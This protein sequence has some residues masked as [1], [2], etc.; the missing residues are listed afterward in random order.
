M[1]KDNHITR[2][3]SAT[4]VKSNALD[5]D[6]ISHPVLL[7]QLATVSMDYW[8]E[9]S[10]PDVGR[11]VTAQANHQHARTSTFGSGEEATRQSSS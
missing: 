11:Q 8:T 10:K 5:G 6:D 2:P 9:P 7:T 4:K 1:N 3:G